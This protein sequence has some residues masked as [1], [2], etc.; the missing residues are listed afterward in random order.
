LTT[1]VA[2]ASLLGLMLVSASFWALFLWLGLRWAKAPRV[3]LGRLAWVTVTA[4]VIEMVISIASRLFASFPAVQIAAALAALAVTAIA[5]TLVIAAV[6]RTSFFRSMQAWLPTLVA[7]VATALFTLL[8]F[9]PF[10]YEAYVSPTNA[11]APTLLGR[12]WRGVCPKCGQA[13]YCSP[14]EA[15]YRP[16][17]M[18]MI[19]ENFH[20]TETSDR[21]ARAYT[22]DRFLVAKWLRPERWD[23]VVFQPPEEPSTLYIMRLVGLPGER[24]HIEDGAVWINGERLTAPAE[25]RGIEYL[26]EA[27]DMP[28]ALWGS[29]DRPAVLGPDEYFVLGDFSRQAKD[30][31]WW[32]QSE[33]GRHPYA[34]PESH[35]RGVATHIYWPPRRWRVLR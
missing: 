26:S 22:A 15:Y 14:V 24:V 28:V 12:H 4:T 23:L 25:L 16:E 21:G 10:I 17:K 5:Q 1:V 6:F 8:V 30:S 31:R 3:S 29:R 18:W 20:T 27:P 7:S 35:L 2:I 13:N 9:R 32:T 11:M 33:P 34:V 19:C